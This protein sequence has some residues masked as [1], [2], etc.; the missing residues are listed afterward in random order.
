MITFNYISKKDITEPQSNIRKSPNIQ[1]CTIDHYI[2]G[3][4]L[5]GT[6]VNNTS[7][8][9]NKVSPVKVF[10]TIELMGTAWLNQQMNIYIL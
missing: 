3:I 2:A 8:K 6:T 7:P 10:K 5:N 1:Q 4:S 9:F